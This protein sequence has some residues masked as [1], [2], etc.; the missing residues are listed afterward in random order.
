M[1]RIIAMQCPKE[2][3]SQI[4]SIVNVLVSSKDT[5]LMI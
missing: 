4:F 3:L 1:N 5:Y 2:S